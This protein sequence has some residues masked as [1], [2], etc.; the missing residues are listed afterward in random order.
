MLEAKTAHAHIFRMK[1]SFTLN[2][3]I[4]PPFFHV[5]VMNVIFPRPQLLENACLPLWPLGT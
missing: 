4:L 3:E 1:K 2:P 5:V